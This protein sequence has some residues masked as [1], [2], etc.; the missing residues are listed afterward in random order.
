MK[1]LS[2]LFFALLATLTVSEFVPVSNFALNQL[3]GKWYVQS[4]YRTDAGK[5]APPN[6]MEIIFDVLNDTAANVTMQYYDTQKLQ[7]ESYIATAYEGNPAILEPDPQTLPWY[8]VVNLSSIPYWV[9]N[10]VDTLILAANSTFVFENITESAYL[11]M[12]ASRA[13]DTNYN[14]QPYI[15]ANNLPINVTDE[16][17]NF[18]FANSACDAHFEWTPLKKFNATSLRKNYNL[19]GVYEPAGLGL[20]PWYTGEGL[21]DWSQAFCAQVSF[22]SGIQNDTLMTLSLQSYALST[23]E[24]TW[25]IAPNPELNSV[26]LGFNI[27]GNTLLYVQ[28]AD[29]LGNL[30]LTAGTTTSF[31]LSTTAT[32]LT[33]VYKELFEA[34]LAEMGYQH[35][36]NYIY[37]I[38]SAGC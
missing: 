7:Y 22:T 32:S 23:F 31:F 25:Q 28:Y 27:D 10:S 34:T 30:I 37:S 9:N 12:G 18:F 24:R 19:I 29:L 1:T 38:D 5:I 35:D 16:G 36:V 11:V 3:Q 21:Y 17:F 6:C 2:I 26:L 33:P 15:S 20:V 4:V 13:Y 8:M 14:I